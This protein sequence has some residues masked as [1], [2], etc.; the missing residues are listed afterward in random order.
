[1]RLFW[2]RGKER[3]NGDEEV[4]ERVQKMKTA[5]MTTTMAVQSKVIMV[6]CT[7]SIGLSLEA[8][9]P[10]RARSDKATYLQ[11]LLSHF[12][13]GRCDM[14]FAESRIQLIIAATGLCRAR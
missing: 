3:V 1:M 7:Q 5:A 14:K 8:L 9:F 11:D 4:E 13:P 12:V 2:R 10:P 6:V